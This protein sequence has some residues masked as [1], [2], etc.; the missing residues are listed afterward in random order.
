MGRRRMSEPE[1]LKQ[2]RESIRIED[3]V[4]ECVSLERSGFFLRG[5][6]PFVPG[7]DR[8]LVVMPEYGRFR[9][10]ASGYTGDVF[11]WV[12]LIDGCSF[13]S[14]VAKLAES[15]GIEQAL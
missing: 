9:C 2:V 7:D 14:A 12:Q 15:G 10:C 4:R 3:L 5:A 1:F 6:S 8:S 11:A 13:E